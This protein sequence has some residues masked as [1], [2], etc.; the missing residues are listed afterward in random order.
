VVAAPRLCLTNQTEA[1]A[2]SLVPL[3][4]IALM[5]QPQLPSP[6]NLC[7]CNEADQCH[8]IPAI[9]VFWDDIP[10]Y[11]ILSHR[12]G[13]EEVSFAQFS[14]SPATAEQRK[15][16]EK[17]KNCA[18][19]AK[20][21]DI[22]WC[23]VDTC[24]IDKCSSSELSEAI[25]SIYQWYH[26]AECCYVYLEDVVFGKERIPFIPAGVLVDSKWF[27]R[28][29]TLQE[30]IAPRKLVFYSSSWVNI[31]HRRLFSET[32]SYR[33][34][35]D[36]D[37]LDGEASIDSASIAQ[38]MRWASN[39]ETTRVEDIAY[40][41]M[42]LFDVNMPL[43]YG[44]GRKAFLRLQEEIIKRS[45]DQSIFSW[46]DTTATRTTLCGLLAR[47]ANEFRHC[48]NIKR[49][50]TGFAIPFE[51]TN[52]G[53]HISLP[54]KAIDFHPL[55]YKAVL[56]CNSGGYRNL[57]VIRLRRTHTNSTQFIRVDS[58]MEFLDEP[59]GGLT[60]IA[61]YVLEKV[62]DSL[63][64]GTRVAAVRVNIETTSF[65]QRGIWA[66]YGLLKKLNEVRFDPRRMEM[67]L[68]IRLLFQPSHRHWA[69]RNKRNLVTLHCDLRG[70]MTGEL[71][72]S[73][74]NA[75][76]TIVDAR[77]NISKEPLE[78]NLKES[79]PAV[80]QLGLQ[81]KKAVIGD[82]IMFVVSMRLSYNIIREAR[83][84]NN[85]RST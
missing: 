28:G 78:K 46:I 44:E 58:H 22:D 33:Y 76:V 70:Y 30:L 66:P 40:S 85:V 75:T 8:D 65:E 12:W 84:R 7:N 4:S 62:S 59:E 82:E 49:V 3:R 64:V 79:S 10:P 1:N 68:P 52:M 24:C 55:E 6:S 48:Q 36:V 42:G 5:D 74:A 11:A 71:D 69:V 50:D 23:W 53:L 80:S 16:F 17:I 15:G 63:N 26:N 19:Q 31:G 32:I 57:V 77:Y 35:I 37:I 51:V 83:D 21:E 54:M 13:E 43:L 81:G 34:G 67:S 39:R 38:R 61:L 73:F 2:S 41:L 14:F 29:W 20:K 72:A 47:G 25:N 56:G 60:P 9:R 18:T 27:S 45:G